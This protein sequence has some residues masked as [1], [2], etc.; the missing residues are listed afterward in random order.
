LPGFR[1]LEV[2]KQDC[3]FR[4]T[5]KAPKANFSDSLDEYKQ[6]YGTL[7]WETYLSQINFLGK[8]I[9][10]AHEQNTKVLI[11]SMP[12]TDLNRQLL[13]DFKW[14][15]YKESI[16]VVALSEGASFLD[17][18][19]SGQFSDQDFM[20]TVHLHAQGGIKLLTILANYLSKDKTIESALN[21][22]NTSKALTSPSI[23]A[24]KGA[25]I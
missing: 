1:P 13:G 22:N 5:T 8:M 6:R 23:A 11:V 25:S 16:K 10:K 17:L 15:L 14:K 12:I 2:A 21:S 4:P 18:E 7:K 3:F 20:D 9:A 19:S 24:L